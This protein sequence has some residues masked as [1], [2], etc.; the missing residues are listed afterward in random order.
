VAL[1][2]YI[3]AKME[4]R[5][6]KLPTTKVERKISCSSPR[7]VKEVCEPQDLPNP[8]P[9]VCIKI[10]RDRIRPKM[11]CN[12]KSHVFMFDLYYSF[13]LFC[14]PMDE[15]CYYRNQKRKGKICE[16]P[17]RKAC[18]RDVQVLG[19]ETRIIKPCDLKL[20]KGEIHYV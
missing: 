16:W 9:F 10:K 17:C 12:D 13:F 7:L 8:V 15:G 18:G 3:T 14:Y 20:R 1:F 11:I 4:M 6:N 19:C 5:M 2:D